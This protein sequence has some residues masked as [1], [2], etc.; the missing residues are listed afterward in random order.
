MVTGMT[1]GTNTF[2]HISRSQIVSNTSDGLLASASNATI[3]VENSEIA[4]NANGVRAGAS[5]ATI[6]IAG[7]GI[8]NNTNGVA[9]IPAGGTIASD[10]NNK[11]AG[12]GASAA[13]NAAITKQ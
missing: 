13:P 10:G 2:G 9:V 1:V 5:G 7:N 3:N 12:N 4:F 6:R 11:V 8:Y